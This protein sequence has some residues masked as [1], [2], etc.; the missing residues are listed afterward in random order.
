M[1]FAMA[2]F[3]LNFSLKAKNITR[4]KREYHFASAKY[5]ISPKAKYITAIPPS[6]IAL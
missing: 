5:H 2:N 4:A 1:K 6:G 3:H